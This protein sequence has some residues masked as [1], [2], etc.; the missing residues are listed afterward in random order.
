MEK[1]DLS[2]F[3]LAYTMTEI[4][5]NYNDMPDTDISMCGLPIDIADLAEAKE[6]AISYESPHVKRFW[7]VFN[8]STVLTRTT[9]YSKYGIEGKILT[10]YKIEWS[11]DGNWSIE[12]IG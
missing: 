8:S 9:N 6:L 2:L 7:A 5:R 4:V 11:I 12:K 10:I 3:Q 1:T